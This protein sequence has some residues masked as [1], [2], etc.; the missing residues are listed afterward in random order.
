MLSLHVALQPLLAA[1]P[2]EDEGIAE[3]T[4]QGRRVHIHL[5]WRTRGY[6]PWIFGKGGIRPKTTKRNSTLILSLYIGGRKYHIL[7][8]S[9]L[10]PSPRL[11]RLALFS[12]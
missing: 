1:I 3:K 5:L 7:M 9:L 12:L 6:W 2:E 4:A 10:V 11:F 8:I